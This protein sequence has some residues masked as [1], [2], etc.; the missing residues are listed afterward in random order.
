MPV[1]G[2]E[3]ILR[4]GKAIGVTSSADYGHTIGAPIVCGF[5]PAADAVHEH[6]ETEVYGEAIPAKRAPMPLYDPQGLRTRA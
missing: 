4:D 3:A 1:N 5:V 2:G 6:Y